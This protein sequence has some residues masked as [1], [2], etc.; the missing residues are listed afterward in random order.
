SSPDRT[1][2]T[3]QRPLA[4][5]SR[6]MRG[7]PASRSLFPRRSLRGGRT[8]GASGGEAP[9]VPSPGP[10]CGAL[11]SPPSV[12]PRHTRCS[13][14]RPRE[15]RIVRPPRVHPRPPVRRS[16]AAGGAPTTGREGMGMLNKLGEKA[17][18]VAAAL[19]G[20]ER[21][22]GKGVVMKLGDTGPVEVPV[23]STGSLGLDRALGV[24]GYPRGRV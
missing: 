16:A 4:S 19:A 9:H 7:V 10:P 22:F 1:P 15:R 3:P 20:L 12:R 11:P 18:A 24:G 13:T 21:Q 6:V 17:K 8:T 14:P 23:I 5:T 2:L